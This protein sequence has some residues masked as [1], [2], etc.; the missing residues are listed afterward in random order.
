MGYH[1]AGFEVVGVDIDPQ[2]NYPFRFIQ[3][4]A[5]TFPL[6]GFAASHASP[7]CQAYSPLN[8]YNK[9]T[10]PDL[11]NPIRIRLQASGLPYVIEN[12]PQAPLRDPVELCGPMFGLKVYRH[13]AF[14]A[15]FRLDTPKHLPHVALC[16]RNGYLPTPERPFMSIHGGKHSRAWQ[17]KAREVMGTPWMETIK[18][19]CESIPPAYTEHIGHQLRAAVR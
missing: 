5:M 13:R 17:R 11:V 15:S 7:P 4:D 1:L 10:Y 2:P 6:A 9:V 12:V 14:E 18:E 19:V 8:A 16:T 3:A